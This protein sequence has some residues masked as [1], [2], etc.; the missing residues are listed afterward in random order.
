MPRACGVCHEVLDAIWRLRSLRSAETSDGKLIPT[1]T[2]QND[3]IKM[4]NSRNLTFLKK[5]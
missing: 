3:I 4:V 1:E 5:K 2:A